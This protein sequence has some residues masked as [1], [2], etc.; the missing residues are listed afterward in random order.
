ML[1]SQVDPNIEQHLEY[2]DYN[3]EKKVKKTTDEM[4]KK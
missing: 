2:N 3:I 4:K 1:V